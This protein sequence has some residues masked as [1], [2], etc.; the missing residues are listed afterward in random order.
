[1]FIFALFLFLYLASQLFVIYSNSAFRIQARG[2]L[3]GMHLGCANSRL[4]GA[5]AKDKAPRAQDSR[6]KRIPSFQDK[7]LFKVLQSKLA[8]KQELSNYVM[9]FRYTLSLAISSVNSSTETTGYSLCCSIENTRSFA[10][11]CNFPF[12]YCIMSGLK[13]VIW[14]KQL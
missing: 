3:W 1:M 14:T 5:T 7:Y 11:W 12:C 13:T 8:G 6:L 2:Y 10:G 9:I 4:A